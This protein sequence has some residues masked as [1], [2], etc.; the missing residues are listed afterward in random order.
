MKKM[1]NHTSETEELNSP[2]SRAD[3]G[4]EKGEFHSLKF[5][6]DESQSSSSNSLADPIPITVKKSLSSS[7]SEPLIRGIVASIKKKN[8]NP[9]S[10]KNIPD[11]D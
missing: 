4:S 11:R 8:T 1:Q 9:Y 5:K 3:Y 10:Y 2:N 7:N 6:N